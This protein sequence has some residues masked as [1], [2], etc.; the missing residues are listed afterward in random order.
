MRHTPSFA[1]TEVAAIKRLIRENPWATLVSHTDSG[2]LVAS[3]YPVILEESGEGASDGAAEDIVLVSHVGRPDEQ[4][5]ELG[6]HELLLIIQGPHGYISPGWYDAKPAVPTWNFVTAH[7]TGTPELLS[8]DEN[9]RVLDRLVDNFED[10]MR[11]P[12]RLNATVANSEY[13]A[14]IVQGTVGFRLRVTRFTAKNKMSQ[15]RPVETV[16]RII[17]ELEGSGPYASPTLAAEMRRVHGA[18]PADGTPVGIPARG[19]AE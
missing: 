11:E 14:R 2:E 12:R 1:L 8:D 3:H 18:G 19:G 10:R 4:L 16:E 5:H 13:A 9:L 6:R 7:L 17:G 15:N